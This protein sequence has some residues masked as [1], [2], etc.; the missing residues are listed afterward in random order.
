[1]HL[2]LLNKAIQKTAEAIGDLI[3][4]KITNNIRKVSKSS[5]QNNSERETE[6]LKERYISPEKRQQVIEEPRSI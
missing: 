3:S 2:K 4:N 1:M 6:I 5:P